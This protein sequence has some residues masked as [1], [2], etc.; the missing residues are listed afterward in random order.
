MLLGPQQVQG[1]HDS[2]EQVFEEHQHANHASG[3]RLDRHLELGSQIVPQPCK[4]LLIVLVEQLL[5]PAGQVR[6]VLQQAQHTGFNGA[7]IG[8]QIA[9]QLAD[10]LV[11]LR[12]QDAQ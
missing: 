7:V 1:N 9:H 11:Q 5:R 2:Q 6:I 3:D 12:Q 10:A 4:G 8:S